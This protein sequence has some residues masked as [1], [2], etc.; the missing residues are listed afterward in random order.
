MDSVNS[1]VIGDCVI[2]IQFVDNMGIIGLCYYCEMLNWMMIGEQLMKCD[3][4]V[5]VVCN[6]KEIQ[7]DVSVC[8]DCEGNSKINIGVGFF[9]YMF[10]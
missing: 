2:D 7:I 4:Y 8:L 5:Y 1:Y 9:D 6:I 3:C 10:D